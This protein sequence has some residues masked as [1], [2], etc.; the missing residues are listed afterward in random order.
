MTVD[1]QHLLLDPNNFRFQDEQAFLFADEKR[2]HETGVQERALTR[3]RAEALSDLKSS[4]LTNGFLPFERIVVRPYDTDAAGVARYVVV[5]GNRRIAALKWIASDHAAGVSIPT[6][7]EETLKNVPVV[8]IDST[9]D[10]SIV[11]SLM[12]V[13]HVAGIKEWGGYQRAKLVAELRD[14]F[15]LETSEIAARLGMSAHEVN[16][17]YRGFKSLEQMLK[18]E[19]FGDRAIPKMYPL[20]HEAVAGT[21]IKDWLG[22]NDAEARFENTDNLHSFYSLIVPRETED[23]STLESKIQTREAVRDLRE[24][25]PISEARRILFDP[26]KT[27]SEALA[28]AKAE[29][30]SRSWAIQVAEAV[31]AL[32]SVS[33]YD[34]KRLTGDDLTALQHLRD[35]AVELLETHQILAGHTDEH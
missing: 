3:I 8:V 16:R 4:I 14:R 2:F 6:Q 23:G 35:V 22:W 7:V 29:E 19:E 26:D 11:L 25:I 15:R 24:I 27:Y 12:G 34:L 21:V 33:A 20:F 1:L 28:L 9:E 32:H 13:R 5:E 17:R 30:L 18:D 31:A 10:P